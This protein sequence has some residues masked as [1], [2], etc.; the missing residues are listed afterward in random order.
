MGSKRISGILIALSSFCLSI[1]ML[2]TSV[3]GNVYDRDFFQT[4]YAKLG[5]DKN[6]GMSMDD[7]MKATDAL[8][9]YCQGKR[10]DL[11]V[12]VSVDGN[13]QQAFGDPVEVSHM[14]DVRTLAL[15]G[16][17]VRNYL[18]LAFAALLILGILIG[19]RSFL[20]LFKPLLWGLL[21]SLAVMALLGI[22]AASDFDAFWTVFHRVLFSNN[23]WLLDP[24]TS[25]LIN[26]VPLE[27]FFALVMRI[28][29]YYGIAMAVG[30]GACVFGMIAHKRKEVL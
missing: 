29:L 22:F 17:A 19:R 9:L 2:L 10:A 3:Y 15:T 26:M 7:L 8:L 12:T 25:I 4:T 1:A 6:T 18:F 20:S 30:C 28:L 11:S 13:A 14:V 23:L 5:I 27:F 24:S 16:V 21:A